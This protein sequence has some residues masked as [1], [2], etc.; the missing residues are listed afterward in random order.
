MPDSLLVL[1]SI[2]SG[3]G[4]VTAVWDVSLSVSAGQILAL[5]GNNGAGKTTILRTIMGLQRLRHGRVILDGR[6]LRRVSTHKRVRFGMSFVQ[7]GKRVFRQRTVEENLV[8]AGYGVRASRAEITT[9]LDDVYALFPM[10]PQR[11]GEN[12]GTLSGGQQQMLAIGQAI[13][14]QPRLVLLDEPSA[15]LAPLV[16]HEMYSAIS[17]IRAQTGM[18]IVIVEH[19]LEA[20][21]RLADEVILIDSGRVAHGG[22]ST[23]DPPEAPVRTEPGIRPDMVDR[24]SQA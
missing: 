4:D 2:Q 14:T 16:V 5:V 21:S 23:T 6:D 24:K 18:A 13:M 10:L 19:D 11:R 3:Y 8:I 12:A 1:E 20:V 7:G 15:G 22:L 9:R 17:T